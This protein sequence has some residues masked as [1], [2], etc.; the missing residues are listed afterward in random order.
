MPEIVCTCI[1]SL[2]F[3]KG[4]T[5]IRVIIVHVPGNYKIL[6]VFNITITFNLLKQLFDTRVLL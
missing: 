4:D 6:E 5:D 2:A 3:V 1:S